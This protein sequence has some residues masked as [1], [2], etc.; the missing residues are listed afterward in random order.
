MALETLKT[1]A[2]ES[3]LNAVKIENEK[4]LIIEDPQTLV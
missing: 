4:T 2:S 1:T 3:W